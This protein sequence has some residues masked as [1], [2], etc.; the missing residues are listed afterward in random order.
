MALNIKSFYPIDKDVRVPKKDDITAGV[1]S[2]ETEVTDDKDNHYK[3][4]EAHQRA[5]H[6]K[7]LIKYFE[8]NK[9]KRIDI[10]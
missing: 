1:T 6:L 10:L 5:K 8:E 2:S 3:D 9:K 4:L 7:F